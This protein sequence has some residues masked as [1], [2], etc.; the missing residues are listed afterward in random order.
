MLNSTRRIV[1]LNLILYRLN[2]IWYS[3]LP[4]ALWKNDWIRIT[5][6]KKIRELLS[7]ENKAYRKKA[8]SKFVQRFIFLF[9]TFE[10]YSHRLFPRISMTWTATITVVIRRITSTDNI[11]LCYK[12]VL[13]WGKSFWY[14]AV[15][16]FLSKSLILRKEIILNICKIFWHK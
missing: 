12:Y 14:F 6:Q 1:P 9:D 15:N 16:Q 8:K 10:T 5:N 7:R 13:Q 4:I 11:F 2:I 3:N